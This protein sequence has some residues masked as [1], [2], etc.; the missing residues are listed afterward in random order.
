[1]SIEIEYTT[2]IAPYYRTPRMPLI[3][4]IDS[5]HQYSRHVSSNPEKA[6]CKNLV[7]FLSEAELKGTQQSFTSS[8]AKILM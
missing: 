3:I 8:E 6:S 1:M 7:R 2:T 5:E 4:C